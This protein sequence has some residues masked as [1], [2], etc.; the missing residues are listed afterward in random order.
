MLENLTAATRGESAQP[1][2]NTPR[3]PSGGHNPALDGLRALAVLT[4]FFHHMGLVPGG[5]L[6]VDLFLVLSGFLITGLLLAERDR[7][8]WIS[9]R[10][11][12]ARRAFRLLPAFYIFVAAGIPLVLLFKDADDQWQF[13]RNGLAAV[14]YVANIQRTLNPPDSGAWF[15]HVWTLSLEEQFYL[16]W[17]IALVA[18]CRNGR[19]RRCLPEILISLVIIVLIWR[20]VLISTGASNLRIYYAP[21]TRFDSLLVGCLLAVW[22]YDSLR[23]WASP[24]HAARAT[25]DA[26]LRRVAFFSPVA[27][28]AIVVLFATGP[29]LVGRPTWMA[30]GGY[31][32][33]AVLAAVAILGADQRRPGWYYRM[34]SCRPASWV[35]RISYSLY[36]WHFPVTG[37]ANDSLVPRY[38]RVPS[39]GA[40]LVVSLGLASASYYL[41]ERPV[42]R[43]RPAWVNARGTAPRKGRGTF[44]P[45]AAAPRLATT[46]PRAMSPRP[47]SAPMTAGGESVPP[48]GS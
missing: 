17:P 21:D 3:T 9:L 28:V 45:P 31:L 29:D 20:E 37:V 43:R 34:L 27:L 24:R 35:G 10:A 6:G 1:A 46:Q 14:F 40:A 13:L 42:Q 48:A 32:L 2:G 15:G 39:A 25:A 41:V 7:E 8:G 47:T 11:F 19:L 22:R 4:V 38:G 36:L 44:T 18:I 30:R 33:V 26:I 16:V 23:G 12:W 5:Y